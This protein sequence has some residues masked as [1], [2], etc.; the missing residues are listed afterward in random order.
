MGFPSL[1]ALSLELILSL[2]FLMTS[3]LADY[4]D[5][6]PFIPAE[7]GHSPKCAKQGTSYCEY[8][9]NYPE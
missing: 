3:S 6:N 5:K 9:D 7:P 1:P 4:S 2:L 8:V